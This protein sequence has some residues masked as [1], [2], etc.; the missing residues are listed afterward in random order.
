MKT[1][2]ISELAQRA[3]LSRSTLLYY[4]Q[5]GLLPPSGRT[6]SGYRA[7]TGQDCRR[8][9][10]IC[11][12][13]Q[14]GLTL[15]D[16]KRVLM[17]RGKPRARVLEKRLTAT[18]KEMDSLRNQQKLLEGMLKSV[19]RRGT[20]TVNKAMWVEMLQAAGMSQQSMHR[21]HTEF[22]RRSPKGH[23]EF[24]TS[25]GLPKAEILRI[26]DWSAKSCGTH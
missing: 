21:W 3:G 9:K 15:A 24:L 7:Y 18:G 20:T 12:F 22:E 17:A 5:I 25:L 23:H 2:R 19:T 4:D 8:L 11:H 14:T 10:R 1:Y 16:I 13:R 26:R 6:P